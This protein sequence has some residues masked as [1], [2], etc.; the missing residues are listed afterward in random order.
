M[1]LASG[2]AS[3]IY[4]DQ[5]GQFDWYWR[6]VGAINWVGDAQTPEAF[7]ITTTSGE[8][9][10]LDFSLLHI[11]GGRGG[12]RQAP[13]SAGNARRFHEADSAHF[14]HELCIHAPLPLVCN[15]DVLALLSVASGE[16]VW[17]RVLND[18]GGLGA[19]A[20]SAGPTGSSPVA[21]TVSRSG[22]V[23]R[24]F[25][26]SDGKLAWETRLEAREGC[27][28]STVA[29]RKAFKD[30]PAVA[31][32]GSCGGLSALDVR[33]GSVVGSVGENASGCDAAVTSEG[34]V[35]RRM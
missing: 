33:D 4:E 19:A 18:A 34:C 17:R 25:S 21:I 26:A 9:Q 24:A 29:I 6:G 13:R 27:E 12:G 8:V 2:L 7:L 11:H 15:A 23:V 3:A 30:T 16:V 28:A 35:K 31:L 20:V 5:A 22:E 32:V 14:G 1:P 10:A